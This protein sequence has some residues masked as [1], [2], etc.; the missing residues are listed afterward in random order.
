[1]YAIELA[2][3]LDKS[4]ENYS[5]KFDIVALPFIPRKEEKILWNGQLYK[6]LDVL[7]GFETSE[8]EYGFVVSPEIQ[9]SIAS[10]ISYKVWLEEVI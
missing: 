8:E 4:S 2:I 9:T 7:Y 6:V 3:T 1:M 10:S 5:E